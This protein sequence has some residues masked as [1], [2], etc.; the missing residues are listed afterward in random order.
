MIVRKNLDF[1]DELTEE[2]KRMLEEMEKSP[3]VPDEDCPEV[4][5]STLKKSNIK[6]VGRLQN[7]K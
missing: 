2:Q 6:R 7:C 1:K 5:E 3:A 4:N